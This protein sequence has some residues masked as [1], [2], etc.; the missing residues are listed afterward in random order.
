MVKSFFGRWNA[1][2]GVIVSVIGLL[3]A[4]APIVPSSTFLGWC[5]FL[6]VRLIA[7]WFIIVGVM[8]FRYGIRLPANVD[9]TTVM[10]RQ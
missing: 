9:Y 8:L 1:I 2:I 4:A 5:A 3:G 7:I 6:C 10:E